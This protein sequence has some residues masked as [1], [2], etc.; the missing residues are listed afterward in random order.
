M[1]VLGAF[2]LVFVVGCSLVWDMDPYDTN[3]NDATKANDGG[4]SSSGDGS[5]GASTSSGAPSSTSSGGSSGTS[6]GETLGE[7]DASTFEAG[8]LPIDGGGGS[9]A[10]TEPTCTFETEP[11]NTDFDAEEITTAKKTCGKVS[12]SD[13]KDYLYIDVT[14]PEVIAIEFGPYVRLD[15]TYG[16]GTTKGSQ[17]PGGYYVTLKPGEN[18]FK[19]SS[20]GASMGAYAIYRQ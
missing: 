15:V 17:S 8:T 6:S 7:G 16:D 14:V 13:P 20:V 10:A 12:P 1:R 18:T 3:S 11:N 19:F 2:A 9:D 5:N 4:S